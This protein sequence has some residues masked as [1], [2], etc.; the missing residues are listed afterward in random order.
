MANQN[1]YNKRYKASKDNEP[2]WLVVVHMANNP[3]TCICPRCVIA[4]KE[5][6]ECTDTINDMGESFFAADDIQVAAAPPNQ[7]TFTPPTQGTTPP[8]FVTP[9]RPSNACFMQL[10]VFGHVEDEDRNIASE[11]S[12]EFHKLQLVQATEHGR[13]LFAGENTQGI[14]STNQE[15]IAMMQENGVDVTGVRTNATQF[16]SPTIV[17][18]FMGAMAE[19]GVH[20][21]HT[22]AD[23]APIDENSGIDRML[24]TTCKGCFFFTPIML[25][26]K[27]TSLLNRKNVL[28]FYKIPS[29]PTPD[30]KFYNITYW[31]D[32]LDIK[33]KR[34]GDGHF[35]TLEL[36]AQMPSFCIPDSIL[37]QHGI[38]MN[39]MA[40]HGP[41]F[42][43]GETFFLSLKQEYSHVF[44]KNME[45]N[46][47][48]KA[49]EANFQPLFLVKNIIIQKTDRFGINGQQLSTMNRSPKSYLLLAGFYKGTGANLKVIPL[50]V[51]NH[52]MA[53]RN[54]P[55][56]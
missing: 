10:Q 2:S 1:P 55:A 38:A 56:I 5:L 44:L 31:R 19:I 29:G 51:N 41:V 35:C 45:T 50:T 40:Q 34:H 30:K 22:G 52:F 27:E 25:R 33:F 24:A 26:G 46:L 32:N 17:S 43:N 20:E 18:W 14:D 12:H 36:G 4:R 7:N 9:E 47:M 39:W 11:L 3:A 37:A 13:R 54:T 8:P 48:K 15:Y 23:Y 42:P 6:Q 21:L 16:F 28:E 53:L 49:R